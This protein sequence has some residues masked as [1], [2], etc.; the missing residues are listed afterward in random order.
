[1]RRPPRPQ[2]RAVGGL[3]RAGTAAHFHE[4]VEVITTWDGNGLR[5]EVRAREALSVVR[6]RLDQVAR[7]FDTFEADLLASRQREDGE[8]IYRAFLPRNLEGRSLQLLVQTVTGRVASTTIRRG[9]WTRTATVCRTSC[10]PTTTGTV[11]STS[12]SWRRAWTA[13]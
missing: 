10:S 9:A 1:M 4:H 7:E 5:V 3:R 13:G 12:R 8:L 11:C 6:M 2:W